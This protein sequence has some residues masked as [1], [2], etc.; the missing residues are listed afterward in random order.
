MAQNVSVRGHLYTDKNTGLLHVA[1]IMS[2]H[3]V[4]RP[5]C[6]PVANNKFNM[7]MLVF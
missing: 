6:L 3:R 1:F 2:L 5:F 7:Y 4:K